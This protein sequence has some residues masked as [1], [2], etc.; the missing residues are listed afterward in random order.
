MGWARGLD[1]KTRRGH[2]SSQ[3]SL[4]FREGPKSFPGAPRF[5][6]RKGSWNSRRVDFPPPSPRSLGGNWTLS[7]QSERERGVSFRRGCHKDGDLNT[8][9]RQRVL[10]VIA[11]VTATAGVRASPGPAP[12]AL[13]VSAALPSP[14]LFVSQAAAV[15]DARGC[16]HSTAKC[17]LPFSQV[18]P[19]SP[20][21]MF[22]ANMGSLSPKHA[23]QCTPTL[24]LDT[25]CGAQTL[26]QT[27]TQV[28]VYA[29]LWT[30]ESA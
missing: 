5:R 14:A 8:N 16:E 13:E 6:G 3:S 28:R 29:S 27:E 18:R 15:W 21:P 1:P 24:T 22:P 17:T 19:D 2:V 30:P 12:E 20:S 4:V 26:T 11:M 9:R 7:S 25:P 23:Q 10:L